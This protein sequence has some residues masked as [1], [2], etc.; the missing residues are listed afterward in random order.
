MRLSNYDT[1]YGND[2]K[3][4]HR[5]VTKEWNKETFILLA[6]NIFK[7]DWNSKKKKK[8]KNEE[9]SQPT[10]IRVI[11]KKKTKQQQHSKCLEASDILTKIFTDK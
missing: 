8:L 9:T 5:K 10:H 4:K 7:R 11:N 2:T 1:K 6:Y 3:E